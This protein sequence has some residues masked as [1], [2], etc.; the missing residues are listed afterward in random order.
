MNEPFRVVAIIAAFNEGDIISRVIG[1]LV[2]NGIDVYLIDNHSTDD[3]VEQAYCWLGRGLVKIESFPKEGRS[4]S[5]SRGKFDWT[6]I[7]RRKEELA[8]EIHSNWFIHHDADEIRESPWPG[9][10]LKEAISWVDTL[11]YNCIDFRV[12]NFPPIDDN[13]R[14][15]DDPATYFTHYESAAEFDALQAKCW[16]SS[17][18]AVS[19]IPTAGHD[20]CFAGRRIFPIPFLL[21]HYPI[22]GQTHGLK[23]VFA[24]R[25][26]RF[27]QRERCLPWH[28]QY[29]QIKDETHHFLKDPQNLRRFDLDQARLALTLPDKILRHLTD[30][31]LRFDEELHKFR[32]KKEELEREE[33]QRQVAVLETLRQ[34]LEYRARSLEQ[35]VVGLRNSWS[36]RLTA[37]LRHLF[38][39]LVRR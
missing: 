24:E 11:G 18:T 30:R 39:M 26:N 5:D 23:K 15:G 31:I 27:L 16:R 3:T 25:K 8:S 35:E 2:E 20:A 32:A 19:L 36:W 21:R 10:T 4:N 29:D 17:E 37:P 38:D 6:A 9:L 28:V 1:H 33:L 7:L 14:Q 12:F 34:D 22:R 13:F